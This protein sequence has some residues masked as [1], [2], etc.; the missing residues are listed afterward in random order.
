MACKKVPIARPIAPVKYGRG[1]HFDDLRNRNVERARRSR[2][3]N[4]KSFDDEQEDE[5]GFLLS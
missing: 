1:A 4:A 5:E 3:V 2:T